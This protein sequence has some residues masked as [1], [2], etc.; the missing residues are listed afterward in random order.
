MNKLP[1]GSA[2]KELN[3]ERSGITR[4]EAFDQETIAQAKFRSRGP[5]LIPLFMK[6]CLSIPPARIWA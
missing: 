1:A 5:V 2:L 3:Q 4:Y 6:I